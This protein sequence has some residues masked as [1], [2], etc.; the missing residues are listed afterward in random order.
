MRRGQLAEQL[1]TRASGDD[2]D[3]LAISVNHMLGK[4]ERLLN[5]LHD[6]GN[7]IAHDL[8]TPLSRVRTRNWNARGAFAPPGKNSR[9]PL[10]APWLGSI[11][12][13]IITALLR[14]A[15]IEH[16]QRGATFGPVDLSE[17]VQEVME[18]YSTHRR[19]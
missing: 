8:R 18:L 17:L 14:I 19:G 16:A 13:G 4:L 9:D 3:Q 12:M 2:F 15:E 7:N 1:P 11:S 10:I 5:E 6:V